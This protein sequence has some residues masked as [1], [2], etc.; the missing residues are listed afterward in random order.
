MNRKN[1]TGTLYIDLRKAFV[2]VKHSCLLSKLPYYGNCGTELS[3]I[4]DYLF[5]RTQYVAYNN[6]CSNLES[7][8]LE[9]PQGSILGPPLFIILVNDAY[10]C[11]NKCTMLMYAD[12][13]VLL[14]SAS[15]SKLIEERLKHEGNIL[16][17]WF[18]NNNL[19]L[20]LKPG[21]TELTIYGTA[22]NLATQ[23]K[24]NVE[25]KG[26]KINHAT[27]CEYLGVSLDQ[28]LTMSQQTTKIYKRINQRLKKLRRVR[29]NVTNSTAETIY[30]SMVEPISLYGT[31]IYASIYSYVNKF[32]KL[33]DKA[34]KHC[35]TYQPR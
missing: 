10:Q 3:W 28:H 12:D 22:R 24:C 25:L 13:T 31:P 26:S 21:K 8:T 33:E 19:I 11:L 27:H 34:K 30:V 15:S 4:S 20:N 2:T 29:K 6:Y 5:N 32:K 35:E 18:N 17:D 9:V 16:F 7:V 1:V 23:H 14:Y